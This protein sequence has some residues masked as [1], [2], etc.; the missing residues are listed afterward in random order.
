MCQR[1]RPKNRL[2]AINSEVQIESFVLE[3]T[4]NSLKPFIHDVDVVMDA[5]DNFE[6]RLVINDLFQKYR[7]PWVFGS[8]VGSTGMS[9]TILPEETPCLR[10]LLHTIVNPRCHMDSAGIISPVVQM[11]AA[12]QTAETLKL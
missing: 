9:F 5:T 7:I 2:A 11:V 12:H 10:C 8:C 6:T 1:Q 3:A 4:Q